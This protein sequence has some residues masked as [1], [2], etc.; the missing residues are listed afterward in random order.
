M[1]AALMFTEMAVSAYL[2]DM[3]L[4]ANAAA[5]DSGRCRRRRDGRAVGRHYGNGP[6]V[7]VRQAELT[8]RGGTDNKLAHVNIGRL[9]DRER[10]SA[11]DRLRRH[12]ELVP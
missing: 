7:S 10:D 2:R 11:G 6:R 5:G 1:R 4:R 3:M 12:R 8:L 9:L